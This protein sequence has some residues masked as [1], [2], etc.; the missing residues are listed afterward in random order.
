MHACTPIAVSLHIRTVAYMYFVYKMEIYSI[1]LDVPGFILWMALWHS[2]RCVLRSAYILGCE[3]MAA[4]ST[5]TYRLT[6]TLARTHANTAFSGGFHLSE[7]HPLEAV[8]C[9]DLTRIR[10]M[11]KQNIMYA[12][13]RCRFYEPFLLFPQFYILIHCC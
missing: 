5:G 4:R 3:R 6:H 9:S 2:M 12:I 10:T 13:S 1:Y 8:C 11:R 7:R